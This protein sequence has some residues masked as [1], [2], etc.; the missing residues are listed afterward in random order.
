MRKATLPIVAAVALAASPAFAQEDPTCRNGLFAD[1][2]P[3]ALAQVRGEGRA[4]FQADINGCPWNEGTCQAPAYLVP[5]D[6]VVLSKIRKGFACAYF[7]NDEGG[8]AG[9]VS[10]RRLSL[11][12]A[13]NRPDEAAWLGAW[14]GSGANPSIRFYKDTGKLHVVGE[15]FWP[16]PQGTH[17]YPTIHIGEVDGAVSLA[18]HTGTYS[19]END[20]RVSFT[21]LGDYLVAS[22]NRRCGGVNVTFSGVYRRDRD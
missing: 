8:T 10:T 21:L 20:C 12:F 7:P 16:G 9:W 6:E 2:A 3:F 18:G 13:D 5:G 4:Y 11:Q 15:A 1:E 14:Q 19:D 17:D 22:D